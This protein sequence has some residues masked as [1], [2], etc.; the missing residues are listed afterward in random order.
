[1]RYDG[2]V[3]ESVSQLRIAIDCPLLGPQ[4]PHQLLGCAHDE[5]P[6]ALGFPGRRHEQAAP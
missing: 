2:P 5:L 1:M 3:G 4:F 6:R